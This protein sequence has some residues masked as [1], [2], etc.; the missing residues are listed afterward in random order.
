[1]TGK[2]KPGDKSRKG[3]VKKIS[4]SGQ[5]Q[6]MEPASQPSTDDGAEKEDGSQTS[7]RPRMPPIYLN[8]EDQDDVIDWYQSHP[9]LYDK[10]HPEYKL[11]QMKTTLWNEKAK[12]VADGQHSG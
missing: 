6:E 7:R 4:P 3:K 8:Q 1:M 11:I 5:E 12:P 10:G 2:R 9:C